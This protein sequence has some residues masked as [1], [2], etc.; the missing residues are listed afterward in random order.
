MRAVLLAGGAGTRL[1]PISTEARPKQFLRLWGKRS[2]LQEAYRRVRPAAT[3]VFVA[4][5]ERYAAQ[6]LAELPEISPS[7]LLLEP[8]R[9]NTA[10]AVL[11]AALTL[12]ADD[13][14]PIATLPADQTVADDASFRCCLEAAGEIA[15][16]ETVLV[17]L[18]V[19]PDR[20][21]TE[22][23]YV[24]L[25]EGPGPRP[26]RR[27]VEK[28]DRQTAEGYLRAGNFFWNAGVFVF[29]PSVV[30]SV[31]EVTCPELLEACRR[32]HRRPSA[33]VF[34]KIPSI[35]FDYA[36]LE[37]T[38]NVTCVPCDA[39]WNDVGSY[40]ALKELKG[41][42][43]AGNLVVSDRPVVTEGVRDSVVAVSEE[44]VLVL[45][46][47]REGEL[48]EILRIARTEAGP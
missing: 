31:A 20:P 25:E 6:T 15:A 10:A 39:G 21:E 29:R 30:L 18:G 27:F 9:R 40:R 5:A 11:T 28:P 13:D 23:G 3:G 38:K 14:S 4:T 26:V 34:G 41:T 8:C 16:R 1:W 36:V 37:K 33:D 2:L 43:L 17:L 46:F 24:E 7:D 22:Y 12:G 47:A 35:S 45:P 32:Y 48:R 44:G 19:A 42:D